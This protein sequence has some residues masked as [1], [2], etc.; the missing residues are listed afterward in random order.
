MRWCAGR[1]T[2]RRLEFPQI[3]PI[4]IGGYMAKLETTVNAVDA[5]ATMRIKVFVEKGRQATVRFY[6]AK[7]LMKVVSWL[8]GGA[9]VY[10]LD[11]SWLGPRNG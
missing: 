2:S 9:P 8:L 6:V 1:T 11:K 4:L 7:A 5:L 3:T 10:L